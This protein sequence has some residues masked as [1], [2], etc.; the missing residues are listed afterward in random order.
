MKVTCFFQT[1]NP[2]KQRWQFLWNA[3]GKK[4]CNVT[5]MPKGDQHS[6]WGTAKS[7]QSNE[8]TGIR[9]VVGM[10]EDHQF[11]SCPEDREHEQVRNRT[12]GLPA[13]IRGKLK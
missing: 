10:P 2:E 6:H 11:S 9:S 13:V 5:E 7:N 1:R 4:R 3:Q 8:G 12:L